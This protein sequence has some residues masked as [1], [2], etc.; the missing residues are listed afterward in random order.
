LLLLQT[1]FRF[2]SEQNKESMSTLLGAAATGVAIA[3]G[4]KTANHVIK[5]LPSKKS[6]YSTAASHAKKAQAVIHKVNKVGSAISKT[7]HVI[8]NKGLNH[9]KAMTFASK[10]GAKIDKMLPKGAITKTFKRPTVLSRNSGKDRLL[11]PA[12]LNKTA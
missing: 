10:G 11:P 1:V 5:N 7:K 4:A 6:V 8:K 12:L 2:F 3:K 9:N